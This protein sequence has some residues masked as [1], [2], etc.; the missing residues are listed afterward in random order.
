MG[1][2]IPRLGWP[3]SMLARNACLLAA[4]II[5]GQIISVASYLVFVQTPRVLQLA[6]LTGRYIAVIQGSIERWPDAGAARLPARIGD[7]KVHF[8]SDPPHGTVS[9][10]NPVERWLTRRFL[11]E[12]AGQLGPGRAMVLR[13]PD[14]QLWV[15]LDAGPAPLWL[16][17]D[18]RMLASE[19]A[20]NWL[21]MSVV[22][23][24][25]GLLGAILIQRR[26]NR[27]LADLA[28]AATRIGA[29]LPTR[30]LAEDGPREL[31]DVAVAFNR[32]ASD[33]TR[34]EADRAMML[35]GISHDVRTP[36]TRARLAVEMM[37]ETADPELHGSVLRNLDRVDRIMS[38]F[39]AYAR[40][41]DA[42]GIR[43]CDVGGL[44]RDVV[45]HHGGADHVHSDVGPMPRL[46]VRPLALSRALENLI[47]NALQHGAPPVTVTAHERDGAVVISVSDCGSGIPESE[48]DRCRQPF[49][50]LNPDRGR[51]SGLGLAIVDRIMRLHGGALHLDRSPSGGLKASLVLP[52][53]RTIAGADARP[54][55]A[56]EDDAPETASTVPPEDGRAPAT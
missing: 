12:L 30:P 45:T 7:A 39:L 55:P 16:V 51:S 9:F 8:T 46:Q 20:L 42:E 5:G 6:D 56:V 40:H 21:A 52:A 44:V 1:A 3:R 13:D 34:L 33:L 35:A 32:M 25:I 31:A 38:Q 43:D 54:L 24:T 18:A 15:R 28:A 2:G 19:R 4:L 48:R 14:P 49:Q 10:S 17:T 53:V 41:E 50:R 37:A 27:P 29:G 47:G 11:S 26:V 23:A 22:G 36:L